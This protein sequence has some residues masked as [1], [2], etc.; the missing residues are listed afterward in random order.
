MNPGYDN[1]P[2]FMRD[3][4]SFLFSSN[5]DGAQTDI[6]R[7]WISDGKTTQVTAT[8]EPE[9]SPTLAPAGTSFTVIQVEPDNAQ[10]LKMFDLSGKLI[11]LVSHPDEKGVGYHAWIDPETLM[12]FIVG[13]PSRLVRY[14]PG[15]VDVEE[16]ATSIGRSLVAIPNSNAVS[17][18][19]RDDRG[20]WW[21]KRY[22]AAT[23]QITTIAQAPEG[24]DG[25]PYASWSRNRTMFTAAGTKIFSRRAGDR[26]W[27]FLGDLSAAPIRNISRL[28]VSPD[29]RWLAF[30]ADPAQSE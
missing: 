1:Q 6:Y 22:D 18:T 17:F 9:Y 5:R 25:E 3:S 4:R 23:R 12:L 24:G 8:T 19:T 15:A 14:R 13:Q 29:G 27:T 2:S 10:R 20:T 21:F 30:V 26:D 28:A 7:Y 11:A 16:V